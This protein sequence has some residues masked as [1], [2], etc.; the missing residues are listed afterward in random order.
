MESAGH[1]KGALSALPWVPVDVGGSKLLAKAW[2]G[3][4]EYQ[5]L[6]SDLK[7]VWREMM[8]TNSIAKRAQARIFYIFII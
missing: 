6:L 7:S 3:D 4:T 1:A 8:N 2:F 5:L